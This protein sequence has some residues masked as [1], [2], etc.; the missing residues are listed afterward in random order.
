LLEACLKLDSYSNRSND[1]FKTSGIKHSRSNRGW[2]PRRDETD[3]DAVS[4]GNV[5]TGKKGGRYS[6][7]N[8]GKRLPLELKLVVKELK[9]RKGREAVMENGRIE[10]IRML[11]NREVVSFWTSQFGCLHAAPEI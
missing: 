9:A 1:D 10:P 3:D 6:N 7:G 11:E 8:E 2:S 4:E 5:A